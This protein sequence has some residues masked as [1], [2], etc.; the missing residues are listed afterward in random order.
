MVCIVLL[1]VANKLISTSAYI[2]AYLMVKCGV[3]TFF[4]V[5]H[6]IS[7]FLDFMYIHYS[8]HAHFYFLCHVFNPVSF[9]IDELLL[10]LS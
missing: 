5:L 9:C 3:Y 7:V 1:R 10:N 2:F 6:T 4:C 8:H